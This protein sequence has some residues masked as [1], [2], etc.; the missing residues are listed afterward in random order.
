[1]QICQPEEN[2]YIVG[3]F[4][5]QLFI[6]LKSRVGLHLLFQQLSFCLTISDGLWIVAEQGIDHDFSQ[7]YFIMLQK[8]GDTLI[9][10][11]FYFASILYRFI[12]ENKPLP[13]RL[14][15]QLEN[16]EGCEHTTSMLV[17][18]HKAFH[19]PSAKIQT[20]GML[21]NGFVQYSVCLLIVLHGFT[22]VLQDP[23][24]GYL[25]IFIKARNRRKHSCIFG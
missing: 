4:T 6:D 15:T 9:Y 7:G 18:I 23:V 1:M 8:E 3:C 21:L 17:F 14:T 11:T 20:V 10:Y 16:I 12:V 25:Q 5:I 24:G 19:L 13:T 2:D 22:L